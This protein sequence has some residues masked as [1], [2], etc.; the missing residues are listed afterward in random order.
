MVVNLMQLG[1]PKV[2]WLH[3]AGLTTLIEVADV[4]CTQC[5]S[6]SIL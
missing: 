3:P 5:G 2:C 6:P 1:A 4:I